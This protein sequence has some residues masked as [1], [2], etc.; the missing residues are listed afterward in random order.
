MVEV[1]ATSLMLGQVEAG[2]KIIHA[3]ETRDSIG[4]GEVCRSCN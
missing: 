2:D 3:L 1:E 4:W